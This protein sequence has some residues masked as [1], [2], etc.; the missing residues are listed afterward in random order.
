MWSGRGFSVDHTPLSTF[1]PMPLPVIDISPL[2]SVPDGDD[3]SPAAAAAAAAVAAACVKPGLGF[4]YATGHGVP[5]DVT[6]AAFDALDALFTAAAAVKA[7]VDA[8]ASPLRRGYTAAGS[9]AHTCAPPTAGGTVAAT[10]APAPAQALTP[11]HPAM[12]DQKESF[13]VGME[14]DAAS[15]ATATPM[16]G[17]N[18]WPDATAL[19]LF[20]PAVRA[21]MAAG[22]QAARAVARGVAGALGLAPAALVDTLDSP[23][24][25][26]LLLRYP[27]LPP[28]AHAA[29]ISACGAHTDCGLLTLIA[30]R[31]P[32]GLQVRPPGADAWMDVPVLPGTLV[33]NLGDLA[34]FWS[35][36]RVAST[37]HRVVP[38]PAGGGPRDSIALFSNAAFDA[39]VVPAGGGEATTAGEYI[40]EKLGMM[41]EGGS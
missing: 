21:Y 4:F 28:N 8:V 25:Q 37:L 22:L 7:G 31:G 6:A 38:P 16:H 34:E 18:Q 19:P 17:P 40:M 41:W 1:H 26:C 11:T 5:T 27:P 33:V 9:L 24:A 12:G 39:P 2:L 29:T 15:P 10:T 36:G 20:E 3:L 35:G 32:P 30:Q 13:T 14:V 23:V